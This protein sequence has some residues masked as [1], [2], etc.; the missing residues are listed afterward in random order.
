MELPTLCFRFGITYLMEQFSVIKFLSM[1]LH[2]FRSKNAGFKP[3]LR[4]KS[5]FQ[6][7]CPQMLNFKTPAL[8]FKYMLTFSQGLKSHTRFCKRICEG[9]HIRVISPSNCCHL[10]T[11]LGVNI[12]MCEKSLCVVPDLHYVVIIIAHSAAF[13]KDCICHLGS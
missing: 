10:R 2:Y 9:N 1:L 6:A 7:A 5:P 13:R 12:S 4:N 11:Q 8:V 3:K